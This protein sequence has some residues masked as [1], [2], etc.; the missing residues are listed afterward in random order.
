MPRTCRPSIRFM[1]MWPTRE[2]LLRWGEASR[3][4]GFEGMGCVHPM[5]IEIIHRAFAPSRGRVR[6]GAEDR[7]RLRRSAVAR[8]GRGQPGIQDDRCSGG[9]A[10]AEVGGACEADGIVRPQLRQRGRRSMSTMVTAELVTNAAGRRVPTVVNGRE[11]IALRRRRRPS[12]DRTQGTLRR[13]AA[14]ATIP[15][16]ATSECPTS[17]PRC[18]CAGCAM[19]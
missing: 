17:K 13:S 14:T 9:A 15:R 8:A 1:A 2:G 4:M 3:A 5:Q 19:A 12:P 18:G 16:T 7:R 11:Q 10:R 6:E